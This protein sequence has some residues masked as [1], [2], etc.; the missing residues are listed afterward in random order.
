[1]LERAPLIEPMSPTQYAVVMLLGVRYSYQRIAQ[2]LGVR[3]ET[4]RSHAVQAA[5]KIPGD[6]PVQARCML[7]ARGAT[8]DVLTGEGLMREV[9][10]AAGTFRREVLPK[11]RRPPTRSVRMRNRKQVHNLAGTPGGSE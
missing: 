10:Q 7:W 5:E 9:V 1:M 8:L 4:V 11:F 6:F 3:P 2:E